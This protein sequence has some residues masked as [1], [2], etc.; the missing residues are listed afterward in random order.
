[1]GLFDRKPKVAT[2]EFCQQFYD[3]YIFHPMIANINFNEAWRG[4]VFDSVVEADQSFANINQDV[5][6][7][8]ITAMRLNNSALLLTCL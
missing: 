4:T 2:G 1:M 7:R 3:S 5:F 8:E 6:I